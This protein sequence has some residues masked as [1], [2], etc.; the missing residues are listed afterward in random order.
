MRGGRGLSPA[1]QR[2]L[3]LRDEGEELEV[4]PKHDTEKA[5]QGDARHIHREDVGPERSVA[6]I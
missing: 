4:P 2:V 1:V 3:E 6:P 5:S